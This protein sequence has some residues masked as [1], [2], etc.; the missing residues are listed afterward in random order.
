M[1]GEA[2]CINRLDSIRQ[3]VGNAKLKDFTDGADRST[4]EKEITH[5]FKRF[6]RQNVEG[7]SPYFCVSAAILGRLIHTFKE[8]YV[9]RAKALNASLELHHHVDE[10]V[11]Q[12]KHVSRCDSNSDANAKFY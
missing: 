10:I 5:F 12:A 6:L 7:D 8:D 1:L 3:L 11:E 4:R 9:T 2:F